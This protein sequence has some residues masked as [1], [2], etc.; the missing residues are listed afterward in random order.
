M[1]Q[2]SK[3]GVNQTKLRESGMVENQQTVRHLERGTVQRGRGFDTQYCVLGAEGKKNN[4]R[5]T[6]ERKS[7]VQKRRL[8]VEESGN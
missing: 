5:N 1:F 4:V 8:L 2:E 3:L 7:V 6:H